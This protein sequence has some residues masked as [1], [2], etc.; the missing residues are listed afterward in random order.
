ME[1][2]DPTQKVQAPASPSAVARGAL[3]GGK[4]GRPRLPGRASAFYR[5]LV[6]LCAVVGAW[7]LLSSILPQGPISDLPAPSVV[8][9]ALWA[10]VQGPFFNDVAESLK[11]A[12]G[13]WAIGAGL[14]IVVGAAVGRI[15]AVRALLNPIIHLLRPVSN[16][17]WV[18]IAIVWFGLGY[19]EKMFIVGIAVFFVVVLYVIR[20]VSNIDPW[21]IKAADSLR[22]AGYRRA[23]TLIIL[24][25]TEDIV[26]GLRVSLMTGWGSVMIAELVA[27][28]SGLGA[29]EIFAQQSYNIAQ[30]MVGMIGFAVVGLILNTLFRSAER[31]LLPWSVKVREERAGSSHD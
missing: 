6:G 3:R 15:A 31:R 10:S 16:L 4:L 26:T 1:L 12:I 5:A 20:G 2:H 18:P 8:G 27:A 25:S 14:A 9:R 7:W 19:V 17:A 24:G 28:N 29:L 23:W 21:L 30:V 22:L 11:E 13:G